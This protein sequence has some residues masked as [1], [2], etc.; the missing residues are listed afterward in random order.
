V[1]RRLNVLVYPTS[2]HAAVRSIPITIARV[3]GLTLAATAALVGVNAGASSAGVAMVTNY[4]NG[5]VIWEQ[6]SVDSLRVFVSYN[7]VVPEET[8]IQAS[9]PAGSRQSLS[10][11]LNLTDAQGG[12]SDTLDISIEHTKVQTVSTQRERRFSDDFLAGYPTDRWITRKQHFLTDVVPT[13]TTTASKLV[14]TNKTGV[15]ENQY[16]RITSEIIEGYAHIEWRGCYEDARLNGAGFVLE[17]GFFDQDPMSSGFAFASLS[18]FQGGYVEIGINTKRSALGVLSVSNEASTTVHFNATGEYGPLGFGW[19]TD[20]TIIPGGGFVTTAAHTYSL[21]FDGHRVIFSIDGVTQVTRDVSIPN[22]G[23][24]W[25]TVQMVSMANGGAPAADNA[26]YIDRVDVADDERLMTTSVVTFAGGGDATAANQLKQIDKT[27]TLNAGNTIAPPAAAATLAAG[28]AGAWTGTSL[29]CANIP[30]VGIDFAW[31]WTG[32]AG[33]ANGCPLYVVWT[34]VSWT[35][36]PDAAHPMEHE[37]F[38]CKPGNGGLAADTIGGLTLL[39]NR[40]RRFMTLYALNPDG[41]QTMDI[42]ANTYALGAPVEEYDSTKTGTISGETIVLT[43]N[44]NLVFKTNT[45]VGAR[46][47][48]RVAGGDGIN[49]RTDGNAVTAAGGLP[50]YDG[51]TIGPF[52]ATAKADCIQCIK[53]TAGTSDADVI[54]VAMDNQ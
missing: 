23:A 21:D 47:F 16:Q 5:A 43:I 30:A 37:L 14:L 40:K 1:A 4:Y 15:A 49:I 6:V 53:R 12:L 38:V 35:G 22:V 44:S 39:L 18:Y 19:G 3:N 26:L 36:V 25:F 27:A 9:F 8:A 11:T 7:Q 31:V 17:A 29:D 51:D 34:D 13:I 2:V 50:F 42:T 54:I 48:I 32:A 45:Q 33:T 10:V 28:G 46:Y 20:A 41:A 24:K 52:I